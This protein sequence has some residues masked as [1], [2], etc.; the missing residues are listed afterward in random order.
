[1]EETVASA[2][3]PIS[4]NS[5]TPVG[6]MPG[7]PLEYATNS[8]LFG[9]LT[10]NRIITKQPSI[11]SSDGLLKQSERFV[12]INIVGKGCGGAYDTITNVAIRFEVQ[13]LSA[14]ADTILVPA[15]Y[16]IDRLIVMINGE[17]VD[18]YTSDH[19]W[20]HMRDQSPERTAIYANISG[21]SHT[22][23]PGYDQ[24]IGASTT[25]AD[26]RGREMSYLVG[27]TD[28]PNPDASGISR[29]LATTASSANTFAPNSTTTTAAVAGLSYYQ[30]RNAVL[31][32][33]IP[34]GG[35]RVFQVMLPESGWTNGHLCTATLEQ[36][37]SIRCYFRSGPQ[38]FD[39]QSNPAGYDVASNVDVHQNSTELNVAVIE[40]V[41]EGMKLRGDAKDAFINSHRRNGIISPTLFPRIQRRTIPGP[42]PAA[43]ADQVM[44]LTSLTKYYKSL[45]FFIRPLDQQGRSNFLQTAKRFDGA[46]GRLVEILDRRA[47]AQ[48]TCVLTDPAGISVWGDNL[49]SDIMQDFNSLTSLKS[50]SLFN[51]A[52]KYTEF[53]FSGLSAGDAEMGR[54]MGLLTLANNMEFRYRLPNITLATAFG[55]SGIHE[56]VM[57][58]QEFG[59]YIFRPDGTV[60]RVNSRF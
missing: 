60:S 16:L 23:N 22:H 20:Y 35:S 13:N 42:Y 44:P 15:Q 4:V 18:V 26:V 55:L 53:C 14:V 19:L 21:F 7:D 17:E 3:Q 48:G 41:V 45:L 50:G 32:N 10:G 11:G 39:E 47:F 38:I 59:A 9:V 58:A 30:P 49:S 27:A 25:I 54:H 52:F 12:D 51:R 33:Y 29:F 43:V 8:N 1:M 2:R 24:P 57:I 37:F 56:Q 46:T 34:R 5:V 36:T 31:S 6:R 40:A 28:I